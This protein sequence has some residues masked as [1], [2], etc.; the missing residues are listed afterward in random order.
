MAALRERSPAAPPGT[1][2][3]A[4]ATTEGGRRSPAEE[5]E[6]LAETFTTA[7]TDP[8]VRALPLGGS[9]DQLTASDEVLT[10]PARCRAL[11]RAALG[12]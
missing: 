3:A 11:T 9:I 2:T 12:L 10:D 1:A 7:I 4:G 5:A 6:G 8:R